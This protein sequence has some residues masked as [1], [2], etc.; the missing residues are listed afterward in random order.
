MYDTMKKELDEARLQIKD[1]QDKF[2]NTSEKVD[3]KI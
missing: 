1:L 2:I 3:D